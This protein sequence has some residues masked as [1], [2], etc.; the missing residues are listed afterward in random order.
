MRKFIFVFY[1][2]AFSTALNGQTSNGILSGKVSFI[3]SQ[4]TY[5]KFASTSGISMGDTLFKSVDGKVIPVL[6]VT[7]LS[8]SSCIC[9]SVSATNVALSDD[10]IAR[11]KIS[12][13]K[14]SEKAAEKVTK[15]IPKQGLSSDSTKKRY[16]PDLVKQK[17]SGSLSAYSYSGFSNIPSSS[18]TRFRYNL[19][20]NIRNISNSKLSLESYISFNHKL[21]DWSAVKNDV[22]SALKIY[23]LALRYDLNKSTHLTL[24]RTINSKISSIGAMDGLQFEKSINKFSIGAVAGFRP[25]YTNYGFDSKLLQYGGY[26]AYSSVSAGSYN[27]SSIAFMEQMNNMKTDRRFLYFQHSNSLIKNLYFFS[28]FEVDLYKANTD[29]N[30]V[31]TSQNT[32]SLTGLYLSLRYRMTPKLSLTGSYDARKNVIYYE[33]FKSYIDRILESEMRQSMRLQADYRITG[34]L[35]V[36]LQTGY[37]FLKSDPHPSKNAYGY[38]TYY[39]IPGVNI[40]VTLSGTYLASSYINS[41]IAGINVTRDFFS[42][43]F[44]TGIGYRYV[45]YK[46]PENLLTVNQNIAEANLY[47]QFSRSM[48]FSANYEGTFDKQSKYNMI[49]LQI[50]KRF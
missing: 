6:K 23:S 44:Q 41:K 36:G 13:A 32:F 30:N 43:K 49:Y 1:I 29:T 15:D 47:W 33:T 31:T 42:G 4:N 27:E 16:N 8:S 19:T 21:G 46:Y 48:S 26:L 38:L 9:T 11:R 45:N 20:L 18:S 5:V 25:D 3:S 14:S 40:S 12:A 28:T 24:G 39:Q 37:R 35:M 10:I 50:R 7:N 17:I 22:F 2:I 34:N